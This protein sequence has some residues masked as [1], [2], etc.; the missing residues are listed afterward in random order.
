MYAALMLGA[1]LIVSFILVAKP[2]AQECLT[3][4]SA[5]EI[6][7]KANALYG[8]TNASQFSLYWSGPF[9]TTN[10]SVLYSYN[11]EYGV[12][13]TE[14]F[15][16]SNSEPPANMI[17][18]IPKY[19]QDKDYPYMVS[20]FLTVYN[21]TAGPV[22]FY[23]NVTRAN[24]SY[25]YSNLSKVINMTI[26]N[27]TYTYNYSRIY[28]INAPTVTINMEPLYSTL[29]FTQVEFIYRNYLFLVVLYNRYGVTADK[30]AAAIARRAFNN[31][32]K[33]Q[34]YN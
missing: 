1:L 24:I 15:I 30:Y 8:V 9:L 34:C 32:S 6:L 22:N 16:A 11:N 20:V 4:S 33:F 26:G 13:F 12:N 10:G 21:S 5:T 27:A 17:V 19:F 29:E 3:N 18:S 23:T 2:A 31:L 7:D 25:F 14:P 28:G